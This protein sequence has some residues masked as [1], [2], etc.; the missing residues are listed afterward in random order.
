MDI[1]RK[2][3]TFAQLLLN[4]NTKL[5]KMSER[6]EEKTKKVRKMTLK[7]YYSS[8]PNASHPKTDLI[9]EIA[10]EAGVAAATVRNW[11]IYGMRPQNRAHIDV[12]VKKTGIPAE[13]LWEN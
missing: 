11:V 10:L 8:L 2:M 9:N 6:N 5:E 7:G 4:N 1:P 12:L 3:P 13:D